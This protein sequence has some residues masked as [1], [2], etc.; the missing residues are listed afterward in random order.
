VSNP[1]RKI[2]F[3]L[4]RRNFEAELTEEIQLHK[5]LRSERFLEGGLEGNAA[6]QAADR[7]FG[8][9]TQLREASR[10]VWSWRWMEELGQNLRYGGRILKKNFGFTLV[11]AVTLA[12]GIGANTAVFSIL[13]G[14]LL[15]PLPYRQPQ[16][17][18]VIWDRIT[19][20]KNTAPIFASY[21]DFEQFQRYAKSFADI[22]AATWAS[23]G[24]VWTNGGPAKTLVV[25]PA[26]ASFFQT[27]GVH[28]AL[29]RTFTRADEQRGCT[30]VLS[31]AF[32]QEKLGARPDVIGRELTLDDMEC[33]AVGVMPPAFS[34]YPRQAQMWILAGPNLRPKREDLIVGIFARLKPGVTL[35]QA[36]TEVGTLHHA[37]HQADGGERYVE[38]VVYNLQDQFTFLAGR[39]LRTTIWLLA[40]A[41]GCVLLIAC[42]NVG[43]LLLGRA[44]VRER[45]LA[46]RAALGSGHARL[47]RQLLTEAFLLA[48]LGAVLGLAIA[49]GG[50]RYF[51]Y[52]NPIELPAGT[53]VTINVPVLLFNG[54]LTIGTALFFG[55]LP[56]IRASRVNVNNS[57]K[58]SGRSA[59]QQSSRQLLAKFMVAT[60]MALS[61]ALL[62]G[63]SLLLISLWRMQDAH[64]GFDP[65]NLLFTSTDL[66]KEHYAKDEPK[67][68]FYA[69]LWRRLSGLL[70][71][72]SFALG[73][74]LPVYAG[75]NEAIQIEGRPPGPSS[76]T[77][78]VGDESVSPDFLRVLRTPLLAGREFN[79]SDAAG[80]RQVAIVN[81]SLAREYFPD[82]NPLGKRIRLRAGQ[83]YGPW[84]AIVGL[85]ANAKHSELMREMSWTATPVVLRPVLQTPPSSIFVFLRGHNAAAAR[86]VQETISAIDNRLPVG[87][88]ETMES[89]LSLLLSFARFRAILVGAFACTALLLAAIGLHGVL[90]QLVSQRTPE[91]GIRMAIGAT[92]RDV[93]LLVVRQG[94][95][96]VAAGLAI[97]LSIA[98]AFGKALAGVLYEIGSNDWR[99]MIGVAA[100][101]LMT[102]CFAIMLPARRAARVDPAVALRNE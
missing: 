44:L 83:D 32:W 66:T 42:L 45:E 5:E 74:R 98:V 31:N 62:S 18:V 101:L 19:R 50:I 58:A 87:E 9:V 11:A 33:T 63:A 41:V 1:W 64:L 94:G 21:Q 37:L 86:R 6:R 49:F 23:N 76:E 100:V 71:A 78:V 52:A 82:E 15:R 34:F 28:A 17:L 8:N 93:F 25:I 35:A 46:V 39:T 56:A 54:L 22:S 3:R 61:V 57:L 89:S 7:Q 70:P 85:S 92:A 96:P 43:N 73:S 47:V 59:A 53:E 55:L 102:S 14:V 69:E 75:M 68:E 72:G 20:G 60:E 38:P 48:S 77:T 30:V 12:F 36:Q 67:A 4:R 97:G 91:F 99:V 26:T 79:Q 13:D 81:E 27:L 40:G 16:R 95:L 2:L 10:E 88:V 29:G 84:L 51:R 65:H 90:A 24:R 80:T